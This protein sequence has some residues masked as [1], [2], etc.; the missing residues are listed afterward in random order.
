MGLILLIF[1]YDWAVSAYAGMQR[2]TI[3]Q[4][5]LLKHCTFSDQIPRVSL[6]NITV[7]LYQKMEGNL[8]V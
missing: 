5:N 4:Q 6:G 8:H 2:S 1:N 3:F 7:R